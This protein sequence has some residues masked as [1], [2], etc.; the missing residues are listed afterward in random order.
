[1]LMKIKVC[2]IKTIENLQAVLK[3]EPD[4]VGLNFYS[5][6]KRYFQDKDCAALDFGKT[7]KVGVFVDSTLED[8]CE[9]SRSYSLDCVQLHGNEDRDFLSKLKLRLNSTTI[10]KVFSVD[11]EFD[12]KQ[13]ESFNDLADYFLFDTSTDLFGGSGKK[14]NWDLIRNFEAKPFFLAGGISVLDSQQINAL[15][16]SNKNLFAVDINSRFELEPG[17]KDTELVAKFIKELGI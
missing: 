2:G 15:A 14:F 16:G 12:A 6:S 17:I 3:L 8:I 4:F 10:I 9:L 7:K 1:M 5:K 13:L 11:T